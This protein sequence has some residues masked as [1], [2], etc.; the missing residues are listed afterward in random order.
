MT[1]TSWCGCKFRVCGKVAA[2]CK[3]AG[4]ELRKGTLLLPVGLYFCGILLHLLSCACAL[5]TTASKSEG[6]GKNPA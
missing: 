4:T 5:P 2:R 6:L 1:L 3:V